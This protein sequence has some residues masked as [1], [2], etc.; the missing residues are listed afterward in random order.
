MVEGK[1]FNKKRIQLIEKKEG[2]EKSLVVVVVRVDH[3][4]SFY[5]GLRGNT[6]P[7]MWR[8]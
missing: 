6:L 7:P 1:I 3:T 4:S 2:L 8:E 5:C